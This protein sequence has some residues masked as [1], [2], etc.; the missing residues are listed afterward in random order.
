MS[1]IEEITAK[2]TDAS[3]IVGQKTSGLVQNAKVQS[4]IS[5]EKKKREELLKT[6]GLSYFEKYRGNA[7]NEFKNLITEI[8]NSDKMIEKL[9]NEKSLNE[10]C[11]LCNTCGKSLSGDV[12]FC[13]HCGIKVEKTEHQNI[14]VIG[15]DKIIR[16]CSNC[17]Q[18]LSDDASFC[19]ECGTKVSE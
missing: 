15:V 9:E 8:L 2:L 17:G 18:Q 13:P 14:D 4:Q 12:T 7:E 1:L 5:K 6:L 3:N 16:Y 19:A 11:V 10:P